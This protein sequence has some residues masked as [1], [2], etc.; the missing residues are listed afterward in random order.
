M[1]SET[2]GVGR[3][4]SHRR[5]ESTGAEKRRD[6]R[7]HGNKR[8]G[9]PVTRKTAC[10]YR[11]ACPEE[12]LRY[13]VV[14]KIWDVGPAD[15]SRFRMSAFLSGL[16][17]FVS[18]QTQVEFNTAETEFT[19]SQTSA[20][21]DSA[22]CDPSNS[23]RSAYATSKNTTS[24]I[25]AGPVLT[26][27]SSS[28]R[29]VATASE[30]EG[31]AEIEISLGPCSNA[32]EATARACSSCSCAYDDT[33]SLNTI[34]S[35]HWWP[36]Y[37]ECLELARCRKATNSAKPAHEKLR[38]QRLCS[39]PLQLS[40]RLERLELSDKDVEIISSWC[41]NVSEDGSVIIRKLWLFGN[42]IADYGAKC[43]SH[44]MC[45]TA[46]RSGSRDPHT[47]SAEAMLK[48]IHLSHN[49]IT[50]VGAGH[51]LRAI[52]KIRDSI[53][54]PIWLRLEWNRIRLS[55]LWGILDQL[56]IS[57]DVPNSGDGESLLLDATPAL[58][59]S[60]SSIDT[61]EE[62]KQR[63]I[64]HQQRP[65]FRPTNT[66]NNKNS[67]RRESSSSLQYSGEECHV[68]LPWIHS[69]YEA[70]SDAKI[71]KEATQLWRDSRDN[72]KRGDYVP[73]EEM[74]KASLFESNRSD[75]NTSP[76]KGDE[77]ASMQHGT[78]ENYIRRPPERCGPFI[79]V[80]DT[81]A[82]LS[83]IGAPASVALPMT[84]T[85]KLLARMAA[86]RRFGRSL[87]PEQRTHFI[88]PASV[89]LQLDALKNDSRA[90]VAVR[91]FFG[92]DIDVYGSGG[93]D[94]LT[95][96]GSHEGEGLLLDSAAELVGSRSGNFASK[97]QRV[98]SRVVEIAL[99]FQQ[100][101]LAALE[102][103]EDRLSHQESE[104][105]QSASPTTP[106]STAV[107]RPESS[108]R[109]LVMGY[110]PVCLITGDN[111]QV[112][113]SRT[114]GVPAVRTSEVES[115]LEGVLEQVQ[116]KPLT[117]EDLRSALRLASTSS[118]GAVNAHSLQKEFDSSVACLR[119]SLDLV[120]RYQERASRALSVLSDASFPSE[121]VRIQMASKIL[122]E[123]ISVDCYNSFQ[124][125]SVE[126]CGIRGVVGEDLCSSAEF[127][128]TLQLQLLEW[129]KK[130][131]A[132]HET[133]G[134]VLKLSPSPKESDYV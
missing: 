14:G 122:S 49:R 15:V 124:T 47:R 73:L 12:S 113:L 63:S 79:F 4:I 45:T 125:K 96:L 50:D 126:D 28:V 110:L 61:T 131:V 95:L 35:R 84:F 91:R 11:A 111:Y 38:N 20:K 123:A 80:L 23:M 71:L 75:L 54:S 46:H 130:S 69:Q 26:M 30:D 33:D 129:D 83:M 109:D 16:T 57:V 24:N 3:E 121:T 133:V 9:G 117:A 90:K 41:C 52:S 128:E 29:S 78:E 132:S 72:W 102:T 18:L 17:R 48:E 42:R 89:A 43:I 56:D 70:P 100:H 106:S 93:Y 66:S 87:P 8:D 67:R 19:T 107:H 7:G 112:Q 85:F 101:C 27:S 60:S 105:P 64:K 39:K 13:E 86:E 92:K 77:E 134:R 99:Y 53:H 74:G 118:L 97:G 98:D 44:M 6:P 76:Y 34:R 108:S 120:T 22:S 37:K 65:K 62:T 36:A 119:A 127:V 31:T 94:F 55:A 58:T 2:P 32:N 114:H 104:M 81:S 5:R 115:C 116:E 103:P 88:I 25:D 82:L 59:K 68:R 21:I 51:I 10:I 1:P 40:L